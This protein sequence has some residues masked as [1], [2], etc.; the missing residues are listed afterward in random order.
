VLSSGLKILKSH[1]DFTLALIPSRKGAKCP[2]MDDHEAMTSKLGHD[3]R[4]I[5][6]LPFRLFS[7]LHLHVVPALSESFDVILEDPAGLV[8]CGSVC[9][10]VQVQFN[11]KCD[12][13]SHL[14][15]RSFLYSFGSDV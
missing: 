8:E 12:T 7:Q 15:S 6:G 3:V 11:S 1:E 14:S 9:N 13:Q 5:K 2:N 4:P 10:C